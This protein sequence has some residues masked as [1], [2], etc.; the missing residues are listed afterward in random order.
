MQYA[1]TNYAHVSF[2]FSRVGSGST[3]SFEIPF[4]A[5]VL[6]T[7]SASAV[8]IKDGFSLCSIREHFD[9]NILRKSFI[10]MLPLC[11][12]LLRGVSDDLRVRILSHINCT[13]MVFIQSGFLYGISVQAY[14]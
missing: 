4:C 7:N 13:C 11:Y 9:A 10:F 8:L 1:H 12:V 3:M 5:Q 14:L 2:F 6:Q